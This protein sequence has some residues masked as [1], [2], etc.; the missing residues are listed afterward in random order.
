MTADIIK[1]ARESNVYLFVLPAHTS[2][3]LQPL[4]V[5][6]FGPFKKA[7]SSECHKFVH[8][9]PN[10]VITRNCLPML[11]ASAYWSSMT[12]NNR[13]A[14]FRKTGIFPFNPDVVLSQLNICPTVSSTAKPSNRK[15]RKD[16]RVVRVLL[17]EKVKKNWKCKCRKKNVIV[18]KSVIPRE[19]AAITEDQFFE[20]AMKRNNKPPTKLSET[21]TVQEKL[22][23][24]ENELNP[25]KSGKGHLTNSHR[26][27]GPAKSKKRI[28]M[29]EDFNYDDDNTDELFVVD[30]V[31]CCICGERYAPTAPKGDLVIFDWGQWD[32]C[33]GWM[34]LKY[35]SKV[36]SL[37]PSD[38]F[39]CSKCQ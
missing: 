34:H 36:R 11:I 29:R 37:A 7:F 8:E 18:R 38:P 10:R 35:C 15:E 6:A 24:K 30:N 2:H 39:L 28:E 21:I 22:G 9:N 25:A 32:V 3:L 20:K 19:G 4:D 5:S 12:V 23:D 26:G 1:K 31:P 14:A 33:S 17:S 13:M 16:A 27:K